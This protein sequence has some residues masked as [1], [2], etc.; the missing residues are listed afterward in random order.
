MNAKPDRGLPDPAWDFS[1]DY[2]RVILKDICVEARVGLHPWERHPERP[3][4]LIVNVEL[5]AR[6][7]A[8]PTEIIN[9]DHI[10]R[11]FKEWPN[12]PHTELLETL[13]AEVVG[14]CLAIP[15]VEA[16]RVSIMKPDVFNDTAAV[17]VELY[18]RKPLPA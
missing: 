5:F 12:R 9:Y 11:A 17:G 18:R 7:P 14:I 13:V 8:D 2:M 4:R 6:V 15:Q 10:H 3:H 16:A 1:R